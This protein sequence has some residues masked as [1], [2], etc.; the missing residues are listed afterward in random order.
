MKSIVIQATNKDLPKIQSIL[1]YYIKNN[2]DPKKYLVIDKYMNTLQQFKSIYRKHYSSKDILLTACYNLQ[3][4]KLN[5]N[6]VLQ[7]N[8]NINYPGTYI[9]LSTL[10]GIIDD[11]VFGMPGT[12]IFTDGFKWLQNLF[13]ES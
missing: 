6:M 13:E 7:I 12:Q 8:P 4:V 1:Y 10:C 5:G 11:G 2:F 3:L 9:K